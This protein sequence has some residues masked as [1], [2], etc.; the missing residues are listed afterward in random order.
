MSC[1]WS[2]EG[3]PEIVRSPQWRRMSQAG[4]V[5]VELWVSEIMQMRVRT[6]RGA[7]EDM[8]GDWGD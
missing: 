7:D 6:A 8:V 1:C 5:G 3:R 2:W 4:I